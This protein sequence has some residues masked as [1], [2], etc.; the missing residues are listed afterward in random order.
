MFFKYF[1][2]Y[3]KEANGSKIFWM[4]GGRQPPD[5]NICVVIDKVDITLLL[6]E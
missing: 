2:P 5:A 6:V 1:R 3:F 4:S